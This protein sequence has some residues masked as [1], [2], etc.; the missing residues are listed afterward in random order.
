[1]TGR[2]ERIKSLRTLPGTNM[3]MFNQEQV[4]SKHSS[5]LPLPPRLRDHVLMKVCSHHPFQAMEV[6]LSSHCWPWHLTTL[7]HVPPLFAD[8]LII[9]L[10]FLRRKRHKVRDVVFCIPDVCR[11]AHGRS[12]IHPE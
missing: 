7:K 1:M 2:M 8:L 4:L 6:A 5:S 9:G 3:L 10:P 11:G 12:S